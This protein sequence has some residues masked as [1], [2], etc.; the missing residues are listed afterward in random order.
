MLMRCRT[1]KMF[2]IIVEYP[3]SMPAIDDLKV[4]VALHA[5]L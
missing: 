5:A 2:E 1:D 4:G 3:D